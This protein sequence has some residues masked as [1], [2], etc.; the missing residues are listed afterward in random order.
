LEDPCHSLNL[1][2]EHSL[3]L[4]PKE[5]IKF[6]DDIHNHFSSAQRTAK[7]FMVQEEMGMPQKGLCHY[8][9]TRWLSLGGSLNRMLEIWES[10]IK[11][12]ET[13]PKSSSLKQFKS[14]K[15]LKLLLTP[16]FKLKMIF[17]NAILNRIN[18][19]SVKFQAQN[20]EIQEVYSEMNSC[21]RELTEVILIFNLI[22]QNLNEIS[23]LP[24]EH[25]DFQTEYMREDE[26]FIKQM[27]LELDRN[28]SDIIL[29]HGN[30]KKEVLDFCRDYLKTIIKLLLNHLH[31]NAEAIRT[32]DFVTFPTNKEELKKKI[33]EFNSVFQIVNDE[34]ALIREI[35]MLYSKK[36][37]WARS[38]S[39]LKFWASVESAFQSEDVNSKNEKCLLPNLAS[40]VRTAHCLPT[41]S[42]CVEQSFSIIKLCKSPIRNRLKEETIQ[43]LL[44]MKEESKND[45]RIPITERLLEIFTL[46]KE[47]KNKKV[48]VS[49]GENKYKDIEESKEIEE[50]SIIQFGNL[51]ESLKMMIEE[52]K[53]APTE[54]FKS[55]KRK[56]RDYIYHSHQLKV[57]KQSS[58]FIENLEDE[59]QEEEW[60]SFTLDEQHQASSSNQSF[61][62]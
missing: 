58:D 50:K 29:M 36:L 34:Q 37:D 55:P 57:Q 28:L 25:E 31:H 8:V 24:W 46:K 23:D 14:E 3:E 42:A 1:A 4:L 15:H 17:L 35:N 54:F 6:I 20:L 43:S 7:L 52:S 27:G 33:L 49:L 19:S 48:S 32:F 40:L 44:L 61:F 9:H 21:V 62:E 11:Y 5:I 56:E 12:M 53:T 51:E 18:L 22:P 38:S 10:L 41:S 26:D 47:E 2:I 30:Q 59:I 45:S 60:A 16:S 13:K 39:S